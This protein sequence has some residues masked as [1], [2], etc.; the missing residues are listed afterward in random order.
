[1]NSDSRANQF[2]IARHGIVVL[3]IG[4]LAGIGFSMAAS[5]SPSLT[6]QRYETWHFAHLEGLL[7]GVVVLALA[8]TWGFI[9]NGKANVRWGRWLL[10][11]GAYANAI[12]PWITAV[13]IKHRVIHPHTALEDFVVYCFYI[14]G[15]LPLVS[16]GLFTWAIF[17]K[18]T[19]RF[20]NATPQETIIQ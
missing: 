9:E 8:A 1:M 19:V 10:L 12:G 3:L 13:F 6:S 5:S 18:R 2:Q 7:N 17:A 4:L 15:V 20:S 16:V 14:P 11:V